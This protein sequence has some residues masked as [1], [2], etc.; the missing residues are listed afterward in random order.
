MAALTP[1]GNVGDPT[2]ATAE[3]GAALVDAAVTALKE[4]VTALETRE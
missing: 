2:A 3:K 4:L 1:T